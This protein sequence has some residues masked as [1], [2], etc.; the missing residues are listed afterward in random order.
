MITEYIQKGKAEAAKKQLESGRKTV[1]EIIHEVG[2]QDT[3]AFRKHLEKYRDGL[4]WNIKEVSETCGIEL[5][6]E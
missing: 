1:N 4:Q 5:V 3:K 6:E 2:Y